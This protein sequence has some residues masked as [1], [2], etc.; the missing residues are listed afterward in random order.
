MQ[1]T[2]FQII[3]KSIRLAKGGSIDDKR[4]KIK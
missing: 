3:K 4:S 1:K 2:L